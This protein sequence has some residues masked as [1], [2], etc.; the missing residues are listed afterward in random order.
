MTQKITVPYTETEALFELSNGRVPKFPY[1]NF[2]SAL[3]FMF[4]FTVVTVPSIVAL[5]T[6][7][8][9]RAHEH[10]FVATAIF[11]ISIGFLIAKRITQYHGAAYQYTLISSFLAAKSLIDKEF[12]D[13]FFDQLYNFD[14]EEAILAIQK[15]VNSSQ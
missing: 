4:Y 2:F 7:S 8:F 6:H 12:A 9:M 10:V 3:V 11:L 13:H 15:K 1:V 14:P 5:W